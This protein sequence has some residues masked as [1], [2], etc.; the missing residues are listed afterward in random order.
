MSAAAPTHYTRTV[1]PD[2][3]LQRFACMGSRL[4]GWPNCARHG[5][6]SSRLDTGS[7]ARDGPASTTNTTNTKTST[8]QGRRRGPKLRPHAAAGRPDLAMVRLLRQPQQPERAEEPDTL[9]PDF[10]SVDRA[11]RRH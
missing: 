9:Q 10:G 2:E 8:G 4:A 11:A 7:A 6:G 5:R 1:A 3:R